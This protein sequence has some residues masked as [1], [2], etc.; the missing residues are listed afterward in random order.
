MLRECQDHGYFRGEECPDCGAEGRFLMNEDE[1]NHLGRL[2][3]GILRHFPEKF[4]VTVDEQGWADV[5]ELV[6]AIKS[7]RNRFHW[8]RSRHI[9]AVVTT[10]PKG[11]YQVEGEEVRA[12]YAHSIEV[13]L[14]LP[15]D[16]VPETLYYPVAEEE[17]D[18]ILE[19]GLTPTD[20]QKVHLSKTYESAMAAGVH[21]ADNPIILQVNSD[22]ATR[23][24]IRIMQ[25]GKTVYVTDEVPAEY[26]SRINGDE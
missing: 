21:R 12:T 23:D 8:L 7:R 20:R 4:D 19:R 25:A 9:H 11:R 5:N 6:D 2:M 14:D 3:A 15:S 17:V 24:G 1:L 18:L 13:D 26:L 22:E 16:D 10:D